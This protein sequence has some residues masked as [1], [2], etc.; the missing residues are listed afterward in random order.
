MDQMQHNVGDVQLNLQSYIHNK[1]SADN[2]S[3][4]HLCYSFHVWGP[5]GKT[6]GARA[7]TFMT[8][9]NHIHCLPVDGQYWQDKESL[10]NVRNSLESVAKLSGRKQWTAVA[11][12]YVKEVEQS[13]KETLACYAM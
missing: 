6:E 4:R 2:R 8:Q 3:W 7:T 10:I 11:L 5:G 1:L 13:T 12:K 9:S